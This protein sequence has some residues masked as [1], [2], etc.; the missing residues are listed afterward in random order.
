M[1]II[2]RWWTTNQELKIARK[3]VKD[4]FKK[5]KIVRILSNESKTLTRFVSANLGTEWY[6]KTT[7]NYL[8]YDLYVMPG[9]IKD[10]EK[11]IGFSDIISVDEVKTAVNERNAILLGKVYSPIEVWCGQSCHNVKILSVAD[12]SGTTELEK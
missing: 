4:N 9:A 5:G 8:Y 1:D 3:Y 12:L 2:Y 11:R 6:E 7:E 10:L